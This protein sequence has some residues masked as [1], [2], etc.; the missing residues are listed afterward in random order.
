MFNHSA[1]RRAGIAIA[2]F[3]LLVALGFGAVYAI[4]QSRITRQYDAPLLP[5]KAAAPTDLL[6]GE[7]MARIVGCWD[8]CHGQTGQGGTMKISGIVKH[9]APTLSSVLPQYS[10]EEL[11][12]LIRYGLKRNGQSA[13]GMSSY[14]LWAL[15]DQDL[16]NIIAHL[17][18][19]PSLPPIERT[20]ELTW[21]GRWALVTGA[22]K[23]SV[24]QVDRSR[25]RWGDL[26]QTS[27]LERGRY[28][29]N[30]TCTECHGLDFHG[31]ALE[32]GPSLLIVASYSVEQ[33]THLM[34]TAEPI[35]G[36]KLKDDMTW[37]KDAPFTDD[38]IRGI[39][40]F[41]RTLH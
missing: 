27:P 36:R 12:R 13:V 8:G 10:D 38:E 31:N 4:S 2:L 37:V 40:K 28:L 18:R 35:G 6:E 23:V 11:A 5:L 7:R 16:H 32:G 33:F 9:T 1:G 39:Y 17:R 14:T 29:A 21:R 26:P 41:L 19:Q 3:V 20:M 34:R 22:Y 30:I 15:G 24:E 25:P